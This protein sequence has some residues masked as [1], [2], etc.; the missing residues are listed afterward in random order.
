MPSTPQDQERRFAYLYIETSDA[1]NRTAELFRDQLREEYDVELADMIPYT[2][3]PA[4]I[5]EQANT[6]IGRLKE[7][8][9]TS[10]I[11]ATDPIAPGDFTRA[12][13]AQ[14][15][16]PEWVLAGTALVDTNIFGATY[17]QQQWQHAFGM[18]DGAARVD[19][20]VSGPYFLHNWF[21]GEPPAADEQV[22]LIQ[23][24]PAVFYAILQGVGPNLTAEGFRDAIFTAEPTARGALTQVSLSWGEKDV[25]P[26]ADMEPDYNGVDDV[27][28]IWWDPDETGIDELGDET[29][30][31]Y[32][33]VDGGK[34]YLPGEWPDTESKAFDPEG[35]VSM[36]LDRPPSEV[37]PDYDPLPP[38]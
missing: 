19:R 21:F 7:R 9:I 11:T 25:W 23:P 36:Y 15:Y 17:D 31:M 32:Q 37:P 1:S 22:G 26:I 18:S 34:R 14:E 12:A 29:T 38:D 35:A 5:Q 13:T 3:D 10:V 6:I 30:G 24:Y 8:G 33:F 27:S 16:F 2:L 20:N 4:S 28:E